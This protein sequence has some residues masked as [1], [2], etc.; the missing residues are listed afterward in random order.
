MH[1]GWVLKM[2]P[3]AK[4]W[5]RFYVGQW[6][7]FCWFW[8]QR[9]SDLQLAR[10]KLGKKKH[11][12]HGSCRR[13]TAAMMHPPRRRD[14]PQAAHTLRDKTMSLKLEYLFFIASYLL[15]KGMVHRRCAVPVFA[16]CVGCWRQIS[17]RKKYWQPILVPLGVDSARRNRCA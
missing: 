7:A 16:G 8:D 6:L 10:Q 2:S 11:P 1:R 9:T 12:V 14:I 5:W 15:F 17:A 3:S 4:Y 13:P